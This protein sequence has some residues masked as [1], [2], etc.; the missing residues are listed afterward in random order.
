MRNYAVKFLKS[1]LIVFSAGSISAM[2]SRFLYHLIFSHNL[3]SKITSWSGK[4]ALV[5]HLWILY[6]SQKIHESIVSSFFSTMVKILRRSLRYWTFFSCPSSITA[7]QLTQKKYKKKTSQKCDLSSPSTY[8]DSNCSK[9]HLPRKVALKDFHANLTKKQ[10]LLPKESIIVDISKT[11]FFF[12]QPVLCFTD[13]ILLMCLECTLKVCFL[14][15]PECED[16]RYDTHVKQTSRNHFRAVWIV[17]SPENRSPENWSGKSVW[18]ISIR[19]KRLRHKNTWSINLLK[20]CKQR[21]LG[22]SFRNRDVVIG[23]LINFFH[24]T[25]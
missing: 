9:K 8:G 7:M 12:D 17:N 20:I 1:F 3:L 21:K 5:V 25:F 6:I 4:H 2:T 16:L 13:E 18:T 23:Y 11:V 19:Q 14:E 22:K 24:R 10:R 15:S